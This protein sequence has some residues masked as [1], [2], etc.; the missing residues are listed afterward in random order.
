MF[1]FIVYF[2]LCAAGLFLAALLLSSLGE[3]WLIYG[4][5]LGGSVL[6]GLRIVWEKLERIEKKL[7]KLLEQKKEE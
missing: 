1:S 5:M 7:D 3:G 6:A 2:F 4:L